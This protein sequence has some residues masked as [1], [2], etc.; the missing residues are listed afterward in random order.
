[1]K[2][3]KSIVRKRIEP[4]LFGGASGATLRERRLV[5]SWVRLR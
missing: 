1:M 2:L 3:P 4:F 5:R